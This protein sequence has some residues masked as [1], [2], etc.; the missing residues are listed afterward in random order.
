MTNF[1][2]PY[3]MEHIHYGIGWVFGSV[4]LVALLYTFFFLPET[5]VSQYPLFTMSKFADFIFPIR[6]GHLRNWMLY[7]PIHIILSVIAMRISLTV[8]GAQ[9]RP[10]VLRN[11]FM[12]INQPQ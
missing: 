5:K 3:M 9:G 7:L 1:V 11:P 4:S 6:A 12:S 8:K 2:I 10:S